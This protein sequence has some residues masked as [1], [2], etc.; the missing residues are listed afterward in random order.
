MLKKSLLVLLGLTLILPLLG[1]ESESEVLTLATT[2]STEDSGLLDE[3]LPIFEDETGYRVDVI[4]VGTG[5]A[6]EIGRSGD[7]DI[8]LVHAKGLEKEFVEDGY[9]TKRY[10]VMYNDFV[11]LGPSK[12]PAAVLE[13]NN[14]E[15]TITEIY[16][17]GE[18]NETSFASRGDK[19]GTHVKESALWEKF[20]LDVEAKEWYNSLGQGMGDTL[21][22]ANEMNAYSLSDRGT[23]LSMKDKLK[24]LDIV[25]EGDDLLTNPY[26][27]IPVDP[28][29]HENVKYDAS[30]ELVEFFTRD[31]TQ[32]KISEF[33]VDEYGE[34]LFFP[35]AN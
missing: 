34:P 21:I 8:L 33:R 9:G 10:P 15:K 19:S 32:K 14:L 22:A 35:D 28:D 26:G 5:Q 6:L 16:E 23:F 4:A 11:V 17:T 27:I 13:A 24:N 7:A 2:T 18:K 30:K 29:T 12:D 31:D 25:F 1:C 20:Q 3:L